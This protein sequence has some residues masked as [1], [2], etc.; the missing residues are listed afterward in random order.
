[1]KKK[2]K[3]SAVHYR[4]GQSDGKNVRMYIKFLI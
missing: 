1:M 4:K 3:S 2:N